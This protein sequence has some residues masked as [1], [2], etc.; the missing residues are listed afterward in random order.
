[1]SKTSDVEYVGNPWD[2]QPFDTNKSWP[3]F[4]AYL[5]MGQQRSIPKVADK[6]GYEST[7]WIKEWS[8][9]HHWQ[10]RVGAWQAEQARKRRAK[11]EEAHQKKLEDF[12]EKQERLHAASLEAAIRTLQEANKLL[13]SIENKEGTFDPSQLPSILRA[14]ASVAESASAAQAE[15]LGIDDILDDLDSRE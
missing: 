1:M 9:K 7:R 11:R 6:L 8:R 10:D 13:R 15:L 14:A 2:R 4:D 5:A 12:I 3:A